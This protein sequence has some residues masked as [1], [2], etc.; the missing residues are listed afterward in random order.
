MRFG[1]ASLNYL[2]LVLPA[3]TRKSTYLL[4]LVEVNSA[5]LKQV[6]ISSFRVQSGRCNGQG[7][8]KTENYFLVS[9][10]TVYSLHAGLHEKLLGELPGAALLGRLR[11]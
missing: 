6:T 5:H 8:R 9:S 11:Q 2:V 4:V 10:Q 1:V 7:R 3:K